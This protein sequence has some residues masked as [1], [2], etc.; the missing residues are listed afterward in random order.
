MSDYKDIKFSVDLIES[1]LNQLEF[2]KD[3]D[4]LKIL[5]SG[6]LLQRA[7]YRY[8]KF[9]LP[10]CAHIK[11]NGDNYRSFYPPL[12]VA[13]V[14]HCH[15]L[16][17]TDY[18]E[19]CKSICDTVIDH[20]CLSRE[21]RKL[22]QEKTISLW[23]K[24]FNISYDYLD[25]NPIGD[26]S[27]YKSFAS[28]IKYNLYEASDRQ[29]SFYYQVSL[30]HFRNKDY[31]AIGLDRY[32]KILY[33]KKMNPSAFVVPCYAIDIIWHTHQ[34]NPKAYS[35]DT[36]NILGKLFPHDDTDSDR[37]PESKLSV[38]TANTSELWKKTFNQDF[39]M[40]GKQ[41]KLYIFTIFLFEFFK[42]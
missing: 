39:F 26:K 25:D 31:L 3:V 38:S 41:L 12:D 9:W 15:M 19:D 10:F 17:P 32:K 33:L 2:L 27:K 29:K 21:E 11:S 8:E 14:W 16:C 30:D 22:K 18:I 4:Y 35:K 37:S 1:A 42:L 6:E 24:T 5:Y 36:I 23:E 28:R 13:W 34:F 40:S 20:A 7:I